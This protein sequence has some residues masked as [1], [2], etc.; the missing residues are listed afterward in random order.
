MF[1]VTGYDDVQ[2][3]EPGNTVVAVVLADALEPKLLRWL[4]DTWEAIHE[5]S[6]E[7]WHVVV[8][9]RAP[10]RDGCNVFSPQHFS[11]SLAL[12]LARMY[13]LSDTNLPCL[14]FDNFDENKK[15]LWIP[16]PREERERSALIRAIDSYL[17]EL[18]PDPKNPPNISRQKAIAG[19]HLHV[20]SLRVGGMLMSLVPTIG[21]ALLRAA[22]QAAGRS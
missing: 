22:M 12:D 16:L 5:R 3:L 11:P 21:S 17:V 7:R 6:G 14:V 4:N 10:L 13:G 18:I 8:P 9:T 15:Q 20:Q 19:L 2:Y 1:A